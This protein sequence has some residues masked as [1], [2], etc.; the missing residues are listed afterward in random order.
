MNNTTSNTMTTKV[1][2]LL[3]SLSLLWGGSFLFI[4]FALQGFKPLT[5]VALRV[6]IAAIFLHGV[7]RYK[8]IKFPWNPKNLGLFAIMGAINNVIPFSSIVWG[9]QTIEA[10][11]ASILNSTVPLFTVV[12]AHWLLKNEKL[13]GAKLIGVA[14]GFMGV[15]VLTGPS[16]F[17]I[18]TVNSVVGQIAILVAAVSY[19]FASI[20]GKKLNHLDPLISAAGMLTASAVIM[21]PITLLLEPVAL[22]T[23]TALSVAAIVFLGFACTA[24]A[25]LLYFK[26]LLQAG[27]SNLS[28][29]TF[30]IPPSAMLMGVIFLNESITWQDAAGLCLIL[31]GMAIAT[32]LYK[33]FI[34]SQ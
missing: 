30:L 16:A 31:A 2:L 12:L 24:L 14:L 17:S 11:R 19:A 29:V 20:F 1:W 23:P 5:I 6:S 21:I 7:L 13:T 10:G 8:K 26:I 22:N 9:Q 4:E 15:L 34:N 32:G 33:R 27:S 25:Y 18:D 3:L 28:L